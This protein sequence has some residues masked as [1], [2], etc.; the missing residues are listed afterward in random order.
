MEEEFGKKRRISPWIIIIL[1][2]SAVI[3]AGT[4]LLML[5][6]SSREGRAASFGEAAFTAVSAV[7]VTGLVVRDTA[8]CWSG[9]GQ[10]V[11]LALIQTGGLGVVTVAASVTMLSGKRLSLFTRS[12]MQNAMS[13]PK[14]GGIV[15]LTRFV[16][17]GTLIVELIGAAALMPTFVSR[18]GARGIWFAV[19][20]SVS[21]FCNAGFD[22]MG[23]ETGA[24]SSLTAFSANAAVSVPVMLLIITG[25]VG[26]L[27][28]DDICT[29]RF[30]ISK[31]SA[32]TKIVLT[33]T[34]IL[35]LLP[36]AWLF[37]GD[38]AGLPTGERALVSFFQAVTPRTAGFNTIGLTELSGP[39]RAVLIVLMLIGGSPGSTAGGMKLTTVA[40]LAAN[41]LSV[42]KKKEDSELFGRRI[43]PAAIRTA[44]ALFM[45]YLALFLFGALAVSSIEG[46][47]LEDCMFETAS[48]LGTVGLTLG[49]TPGLGTASRCILMLLMFIGRVGGMTFVY[50]FLP[51]SV[52]TNSKLP[53]ENVMVG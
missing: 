25:G 28:W 18:F 41:V 49:I 5:P 35:I 42:F 50:A 15:R 36:A 16:L 53:V 37:F 23:T 19:F 47:A 14:I 27:S 11:I 4:L 38:L 46:L 1:G 29:H 33:K 9:F 12:T 3:L 39:S 8:Q 52:R 26:F 21:A 7:C 2:F 34:G 31:Y 20:H 13:A 17:R 45:T 24:F 10:G 51:L 32:Q 48:A 30:R 6:F 43:K 44:A 40:L 22:I